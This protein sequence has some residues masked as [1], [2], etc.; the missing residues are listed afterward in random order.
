MA[1]DATTIARPYAEAV[2]ARAVETDKLDLWSDILDLLATAAKDPALSGLIASP[3]LDKSQ[4]TDLMLDIGGG[5]LSDE[6]QNLVRVLV[7]NGRLSVLPEI[8]GLFEARKAEHQGSLDVQ[9]KSAFALQPE[10]EQQLAEVLKRK[11][12]REIRIT[13]EEDPEL[14]GGFRLRAGDMV[15]DASVSGQLSQL[16]NELGI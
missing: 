16:A 13:S 11:L 1:G 3:K 14:I 2:F 10:Q 4:M 7:A 12:G 8:A 9:V 5:R 6:G 15:I